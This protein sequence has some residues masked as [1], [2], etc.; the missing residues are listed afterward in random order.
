MGRVWPY[1]DA[2]GIVGDKT[3]HTYEGVIGPKEETVEV[4]AGKFKTIRVDIKLEENGQQVDITY[5]FAQ[6]VGFVKQTVDAAGAFFTFFTLELE[7]LEQK[8]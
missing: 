3:K 1:T 5:W 6:D 4:P 7:K 8:K 2:H